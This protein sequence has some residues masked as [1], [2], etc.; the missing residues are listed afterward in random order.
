MGKTY[1]TRKGVKYEL[2]DTPFAEGAEGHLFD[3]VNAEN[4][5]AKI[6]RTGKAT[7]ALEH[8]LNILINSFDEEMRKIFVAPI[9][10]LYDNGK[11]AGYVMQKI[12][13][14]K[15]FSNF[16]NENQ[17]RDLPWSL[18]VE[19]AKMFAYAVSL[20]HKT[21][22]VVIGDFNPEN[23]LIDPVKK[24]LFFVDTDSYHVVAPNGFL[25]RCEMS[26]PHNSAPELND[27]AFDV[28]KNTFTKET[29][30][31]SLAVIVFQLLMNGANP[32]NA[33]TSNFGSKSSRRFQL[34]QNIKNGYTPWFPDRIPMQIKERIGLPDAAPDI[35]AI[36]H[37]IQDLFRRAF[38]EG[39]NN[40]SARPQASEW[41]AALTSA[42]TLKHCSRVKEHEYYAFAFSC[43]WCL[44]EQKI[45]ETNDKIR[46]SRVQLKI[47]NPPPAPS[48]WGKYMDKQREDKGFT[49]E[50]FRNYIYNFSTPVLNNAPEAAFLELEKY[51]DSIA[52]SCVNESKTEKDSQIIEKAIKLTIQ[53]AKQAT[54][55]SIANLSITLPLFTYSQLNISAIVYNIMRDV[56]NQFTGILYDML[57]DSIISD[58]I[59][60][61]RVDGNTLLEKL[62][63][64]STTNEPNQRKDALECYISDATYFSMNIAST[65]ST[66]IFNYIGELIINK[67]KTNAIHSL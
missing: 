59:Q 28:A 32:F 16:Y 18:F 1:F 11:F 49:E 66:D 25:Y 47:I 42:G 61:G 17:R 24:K 31:F 19:V 30:V 39:H 10:I 44:V 65:I 27:V 12:M 13:N 41:Y 50:Q 22:N 26:F 35:D 36:P 67:F 51:I 60:S 62:N 37:K 34:H 20:V 46:R 14:C 55:T 53:N 15:S 5:V 64:I 8:K 33:D 43:P 48:G 2:V 38:V 63:I 52:H 6:F 57:F 23:F 29:D 54:D 40:P 4:Y 3:I 9:E 21:N 45:K 58:Y 56:Q 7:N